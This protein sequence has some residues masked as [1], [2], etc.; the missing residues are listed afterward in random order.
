MARIVRG[1]DRQ[2]LPEEFA[3]LIAVLF[4]FH[5][6][7]R[8][9]DVGAGGQAALN[10]NGAGEVPACTVFRATECVALAFDG[11]H[12]FGKGAVVPCLVQ[13]E[14]PLGERANDRPVDQEL[15]MIEAAGRDG[16]SE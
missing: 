6:T 13:R 14:R 1:I 2:R 4:G 9:R 5:H 3:E 16:R 12:Q 10:V 11:N 7:S 15:G 8:Q